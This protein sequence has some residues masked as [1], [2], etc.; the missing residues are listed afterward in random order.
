MLADF[1]DQCGPGTPQDILLA[2]SRVALTRVGGV[3]AASVTTNPPAGPSTTANTGHLAR[4]ADQAQYET[5]QGPALETLATGAPSCLSDTTRPAKW[6]R[7]EARLATR[8]VLS[9]LSVSLGDATEDGTTTA[10][11]SLN[12]Y[13]TSSGAFSAT[14]ILLASMLAAHAGPRWELAC[15]TARVADLETALTSQ[16]DIGPAIGL[17]M[18]RR[19]INHDQARALLLAA[20]QHS[21]R[22]ARELAIDIIATGDLPEALNPGVRIPTS[23]RRSRSAQTPTSNR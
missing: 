17:L 21:N 2:A 5:G 8:G 15:T 14:S 11:A 23:R 19:G 10:H 12:L 18:A 6:P 1:T 4:I 16:A 13:S 20:S 7:L 22:K 3:S 9:A